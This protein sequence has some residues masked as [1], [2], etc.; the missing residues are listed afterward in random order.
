MGAPVGMKWFRRH[1]KQG[2]R[3]ALFALAVQLVLSF[4]HFHPIEVQAA[5]LRAE[6]ASSATP[7]VVLEAASSAEQRPHSHHGSDPADY[8]AI[9]AVMALS[10]LF[11]T[12][13]LLAL[14][15]AIALLFDATEAE[16]VHLDSA[17]VAFQPRAPPLS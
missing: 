7:T 2:S 12:P 6:L 4:G 13:P 15:Q 3:L 11:A 14:P 17:R 1:I 10:A 9:C 8:C 16:F 5:G